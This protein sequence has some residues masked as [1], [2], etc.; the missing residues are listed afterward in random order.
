MH[1]SLNGTNCVASA[2]AEHTCRRS[3]SS[4]AAGNRPCKQVP[5]RLPTANLTAIGL[6]L[7]YTPVGRVE[8]FTPLPPS[9]YGWVAATVLGE[10]FMSS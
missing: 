8:R 6:A 4:A 7:P 5:H 10:W 1:S 3:L 2:A 9:F